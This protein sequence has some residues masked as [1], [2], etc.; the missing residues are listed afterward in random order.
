MPDVDCLAITVGPGS[1][2]GLRIG[3][4]VLQGLAF[5]HDIPVVGISTLSVLVE[6]YQ[7]ISGAGVGSVIMP[8]MDARMSQVHCAFIQLNADGSQERL[9][10]DQL[11]G[12]EDLSRLINEQRPQVIVGEV[13]NFEICRNY[14]SSFGMLPEAQDVLALARIMWAAKQTC[15]IQSVDLVYMRNRDAWRKHQ[16]LRG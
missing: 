2:T 16:K 14:D 11:I 3:F 8:I 4:G 13:S 9:T 7:R 15:P 6:K 1:F 5:A 10:E 12:V